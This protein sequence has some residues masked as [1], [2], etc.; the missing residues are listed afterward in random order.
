MRIAIIGS[1][2]SGNLAARILSAS[3]DVD[4]FETGTH[5]GGHAQTV[6]VKAYERSTLADVAFMVFNR[7]T[8]PN[9][10]QMLE[11]L[12][13]KTQDSDMSLSVRCRRTKLEYQ[14]SSLN[15]L[16]AQRRNLLRA[17]F[18]RMLRDIVRFNRHATAFCDTGDE[19]TILD[20][21]LADIGTG[22]AFREHYLIPMSAAIWSANPASL[23]GF[24]AKFILGFFRNHGLLQLQDRP[25]W[26]TIADR[27]RSYVSKLTRP[28]RNRIFLN[29]TV[30]SVQ[31]T[32]GFVRL[33]FANRDACDYDHVVMASHADQSLRY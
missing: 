32:K 9:F 1:G 26:L 21:F 2:I 14:G 29:S 28:F 15:G 13:V 7:R 30:C 24:P 22:S 27:S 31:R 4:V 19:R 6:E 11:L 23:G 18:Y 12:G 25:Q 3:H 17:P 20:E 5:E 16:F 8:Y 10:C 33:N